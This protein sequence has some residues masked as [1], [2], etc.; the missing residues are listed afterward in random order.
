MGLA[1]PAQA[2]VKVEVISG[3]QVH[4]TAIE[5]GSFVPRVNVLNLSHATRPGEIDVIVK[6]S[7][8]PDGLFAGA[9]CVEAP[10]DT[11][12]CT[13]TG[14]SPIVIV[15]PGGMDDLATS[16]IPYTTN[17]E[18]NPGNDA[19]LGGPGQDRFFAG[20]TPD[21]NDVLSGRGGASDHAIY[22]LRTSSLSIDLDDNADDGQAGEAD[23]VGDDVEWVTGGQAAD[24]L[25][26]SPA[27]N[28][29]RGS[30]GN[31]TL[32]GGAGAD[33]LG[34]GAGTDT[35]TYAGRGIPVAVDIDGNADDGSST[36]AAAGGVTSRDDVMT[37]V[38]R[39][40]GGTGADTLRAGTGAATLEGG[41]GSDTLTGGP[42]NDTLK[43][44]P[45]V[46][47]LH[48]GG[49]SDALNGEG[50]GDEL[51]GGAGPDI[52][53]GG[54]GADQLFGDAGS[55]QLF[56][57]L[58]GDTLDGGPDPDRLLGEAG[59]D[60]LLAQ[61]STADTEIDCGADVDSATTDANDPVTVDCESETR[62][63]ADADGD[64]IADGSDNC[65]SIA[66]PT[67][68]DADGDGIGDACDPTPT[69]P[70]PGPPPPTPGPP[71]PT[72]DPPP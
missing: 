2:I 5:S 57:G 67:Q 50:D 64:G 33:S 10:T 20:P 6:E 11:V 70:A 71:P 7:L 60:T 25:V 32:D 21:G 43:G 3:N 27:D 24:V 54:P 45:G 56:G 66:N 15:D 39:V 51:H 72:P 31:D 59:P 35:V 16:T 40:I 53:D 68:A 37:D 28:I 61:D 9:G 62:A 52:L 46:D 13:V 41:P 34:G 42:A 1:S 58:D 38:E 23:N 18:S 47:A 69:P 4:V 36:D 48:G 30:T 19:V 12:T 14:V 55:D 63:I 26:G 8:D 29:L 22:S 49:G 17:W 65:P 44:G